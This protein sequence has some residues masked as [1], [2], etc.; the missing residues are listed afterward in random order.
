MTAAMT[1]GDVTF[2]PSQR[3]YDGRP[4]PA[5]AYDVTVTAAV[6]HGPTLPYERGGKP[7][8][9]VVDQVNAS[10]SLVPSVAGLLAWRCLQI[11]AHGFHKRAD[12][13]YGGIRNAA[14]GYAWWALRTILDRPALT[15]APPEFCRW[16]ADRNPGLYGAVVFGGNDLVV[17][18]IEESLR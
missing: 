7:A 1:F 13:S 10:Y 8:E 14:R 17:P 18:V 6:T 11:G 4:S 9:F 16:A 12:G 2:V 5:T 15:D 3:T